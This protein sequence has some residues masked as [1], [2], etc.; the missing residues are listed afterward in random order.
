MFLFAIENGGFPVGLVPWTK[1]MNSNEHVSWSP[2]RIYYAY[3]ISKIII[4]YPSNTKDGQ[5]S[6]PQHIHICPLFLGH[7]PKDAAHYTRAIQFA[8]KSGGQLPHASARSVCQWDLSSG[9]LLGSF[10][11]HD[12]EINAIYATKKRILTGAQDGT[13]KEWCL[14]P[15]RMF[16]GLWMNLVFCFEYNGYII[17]N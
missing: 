11:G 17:M 16:D 8:M 2:N 5:G 15:G 1:P 7:I 4:D 14:E 6:S 9:E 10:E 12:D 3:H 13:A